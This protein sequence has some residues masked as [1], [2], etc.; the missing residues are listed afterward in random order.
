MHELPAVE[1][2]IRTLDEESEKQGIER[3]EEVHIVIGELS[4]YVGECIELYFDLLSAGHTCEGAKLFF[5]RVGARF[6]CEGCGNEFLHAKGFSCP[7][8]GGDG[9]LIPGT[10]KEFLISSVKYQ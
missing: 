1:D 2:I 3:I 5:T 8:C 9:R 6:R 4:S 10:G 7:K